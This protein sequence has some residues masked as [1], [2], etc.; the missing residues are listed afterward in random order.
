MGLAVRT[1][2]SPPWTSRLLSLGVALSI[3]C[4]SPVRSPPSMLPMA[5]PAGC[6]PLHFSPRAH[7]GRRYVRVARHHPEATPKGQR[8]AQWLVVLACW[9]MGVPESRGWAQSSSPSP[10]AA[11]QDDASLHA[12]CLAG[13][14]GAFAVGDHG[15]I[16]ASTDGGR[17]WRLQRSGV[18]APLYDVFFLSRREGWAVAAAATAAAVAAARAATELLPDGRARGRPRGPHLPA[19]APFDGRC[20]PDRSGP[21]FPVRR[22]EPRAASWQALL[23]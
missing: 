17:T 21:A 20:R 2:D 23:A 7:S 1:R 16:W 11:W 14:T 3:C 12:V 10:P 22:L 19:T 13:D 9:W 8:L 18:A 6:S 4:L 15:A 5:L